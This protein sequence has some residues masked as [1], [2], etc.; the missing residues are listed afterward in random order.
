M[1]TNAMP[2]IQSATYRQGPSI[3]CTPN[4]EKRI[5]VFEYQYQTVQMTFGPCNKSARA[6]LL[7][8][9]MSLLNPCELDSQLIFFVMSL[10]AGA[11]SVL[12]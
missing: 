2:T 10:R 1:A 6:N 3:T 9:M 4:V 7:L 11:V 12:S 5:R 8:V